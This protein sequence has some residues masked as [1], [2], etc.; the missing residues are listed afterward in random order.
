MLRSHR[1]ETTARSVGN[2][3][4]D[5]EAVWVFHPGDFQTR[6][7]SLG[8]VALPNGR[9]FALE[10]TIEL[11]WCVVP[12]NGSIR[13]EGPTRDLDVLRRSVVLSTPTDEECRLVNESGEQLEVL[14]A[15]VEPVAGHANPRLGAAS[16]IGRL[17]R[18]RLSPFH[19]HGGIGEIRF[20]TLFDRQTSSWN[21]IDHVLLPPGTSVG[22]H[23]NHNV[24]EVFVILQGRGLMKIGSE[25][26]DVVDGDCIS[27]PLGGAHGIINLNDTAL[28]LINLSVPA[29]EEPAHVTDL[30]DD[31]S[32]LR[33]S[34]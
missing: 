6:F 25:V 30:E 14:L 5:V 32:S 27:N 19:A 7:T 10:S 15:T 12:L 20:R 11:E 8:I 24:E 16:R 33:E 2:G 23:R 18:S 4:D 28:E 21:S 3:A 9:H 26:V 34:K 31:L 17:D 13:L 22:Q 29:S 1:V